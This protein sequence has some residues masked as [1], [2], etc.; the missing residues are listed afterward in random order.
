MMGHK[1]QQKE[2]GVIGAIRNG[3]RLKFMNAIVYQQVSQT[4]APATIVPIVK[5]TTGTG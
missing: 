4:Y 2:D 3:S 5:V 1:I